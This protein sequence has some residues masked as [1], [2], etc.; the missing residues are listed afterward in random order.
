V[1]SE[2]ASSV[3]TR[4]LRLSPGGAAA[5]VG[6]VVIAVLL[7]RAFV[8][9]HRTI[10]WAVACSVVA[11]LL[12]PVIQFLD[13]TL[14][15][16]LAVVGSLLAVVV[17]AVAVGYLVVRQLS[18]SVAVLRDSAPEA[19]R[20]LES[21]FKLARDMEVG[22]RVSLFVEDVNAR[23]NKAALKRVGTAP[24]YMVNGILTLFLLAYGRRYV[25]G[26]LAQIRDL[27]QREKMARV[28]RRGLVRGRNYLLIAVA[29]A[30]VITALA[31][32]VFRLLDFPADFVLAL[33]VGVVGTIPYFGYIVGGLPA[34]LVAFGF[35][36]SWPAL[37][38][39]IGLAALQAFEGLWFRPR[40]DRKT[41]PVGAFFPLAIG[42]VGFEAYGGGGALY[43]Y[44]LVAIGIS[45]FDA[46]TYDRHAHDGV[47]YSHHPDND[48]QAGTATT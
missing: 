8:A 35:R 3:N 42:L 26:G 15:R 21:R 40:I 9:A 36:G 24:T 31:D 11:L 46:Y 16:W 47:T 18:S 27:G 2:T 34:L 28:V 10:G 44:A 38:L 25:K 41:V 5:L 22:S 37:G 14:P 45:V 17:L 1:E 43:G 20:R 29:Q 13:R 39:F 7:Q 32:L 4:R 23:I 6:A 12:D 48:G 30:I 33:L 19:A